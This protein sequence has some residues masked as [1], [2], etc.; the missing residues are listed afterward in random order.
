MEGSVTHDIFLWLTR[1]G[2]LRTLSRVLKV[3]TAIGNNEVTDY[4][5]H[6]VLLRDSVN[7]NSIFLFDQ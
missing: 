4:T 5:D 6:L 3:I 1:Y 2:I 7:L